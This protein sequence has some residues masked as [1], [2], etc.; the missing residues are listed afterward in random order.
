MRPLKDKPS[1]RA[2]LSMKIAFLPAARAAYTNGTPTPAPVVIT[3]SGRVRN[4]IHTASTEVANEISEV[5]VRRAVRVCDR[6][7]FEQ[8]ARVR[9]VERHPVTISG[10]GAVNQLEQ[11]EQMPAARGDEQETG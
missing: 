7:A 4:T 1:M 11:L 8:H 10:A 9:L 6:F 5:A 3:A 2:R